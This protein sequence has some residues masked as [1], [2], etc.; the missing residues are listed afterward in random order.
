MASPRR[1]AAIAQR[2]DQLPKL[3]DLLVRDGLG[4]ERRNERQPVAPEDPPHQPAE[5]SKDGLGRSSRFPVEKRLSGIG[6][7]PDDEPL[8]FEPP[9]QGRDR[10]MRERPE[11][12][13]NLL[14]SAGV[15]LPAIPQARKDFELRLGRNAPGAPARRSTQSRHLSI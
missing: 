12:A 13:E 8:G 15:E 9:Q 11:R 10:G 7:P 2:I 5:H 6:G 4:V 1:V 14:D 3:F